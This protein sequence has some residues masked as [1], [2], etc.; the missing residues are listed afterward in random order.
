[1]IIGNTKIWERKSV[2][3]G[4]GNVQALAVFENKYLFGITVYKWFTIDQ[5]RFHTHAFNAIAFLIKGWYWEK[6]IFNDV[7]MT[8]FVNIPFWPRLI[9]R[10]YCHAI[11]HA[12]PGTMTIVFSGP[13]QKHWFEYFPDTK[14]WIK[15]NWGRKKVG[16][17]DKL[18]ESD[19]MTINN[20]A[21]K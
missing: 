12:K 1:M 10:N 17:L 19:K 3:L 15:Y 16:S 7:E 18:P 2:A 21:V 20:T 4:E 8:N 5:I 13:W 6:V 14:K 9:P 11:Q